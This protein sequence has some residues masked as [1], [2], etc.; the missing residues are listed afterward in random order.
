MHHPNH[1][2]EICMC[3][4]MYMYART[5]ICIYCIC[6]HL[7]IEEIRT[8]FDVYV[9]IYT[10]LSIRQRHMSTCIV[11]RY[12]L[13]MQS[14]RRLTHQCSCPTTSVPRARQRFR[15]EG[16][17]NTCMIHICVYIFKCVYAYESDNDHDN[18]SNFN[19]R[20]SVSNSR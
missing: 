17:P 16:P 13:G 2:V 9:E 20:E 3:M 4:C 12:A 6:M 10:R 5:S 1:C 8:I 14:L 19:D 7:T 15:N 18:G 11:Y